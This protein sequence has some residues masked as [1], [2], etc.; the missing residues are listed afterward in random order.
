MK[1]TE[2]NI[3]PYYSTSRPVAAAE[4]PIHGPQSLLQVQNSRMTAAG[5]AIAVKHSRLSSAHSRR[6]GADCPLYAVQSR[7]YADAGPLYV[8][9]HSF[10]IVAGQL[11]VKGTRLQLPHRPLSAT[12]LSLS[13]MHC[14]LA[15]VRRLVPAM[16][17]RNH[18]HHCPLSPAARKINRS[19][20]TIFDAG[21][22]K[23]AAL[24]SDIL[25]PIRLLTLSKKSLLVR[26]LS[27][28][29]RPPCMMSTRCRPPPCKKNILK[30][31]TLK[32]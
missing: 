6:A 25:S 17:R 20:R 10:S 32:P 22:P 2:K 26:A 23:P 1:S 19:A 27:P 13:I 8:A 29:L 4:S 3:R 30:G 15:F 28:S 9:H 16:Q 21:C 12:Q 5:S 11:D 7:L 18:G 14:L 31:L 24:G